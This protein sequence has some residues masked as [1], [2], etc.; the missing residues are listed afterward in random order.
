[1][2]TVPPHVRAEWQRSRRSHRRGDMV[3]AVRCEH[4]AC[5]GR[6]DRDL[7]DVDVVLWVRT[8]T[9][10]H[11]AA[12][13]VAAARWLASWSLLDRLTVVGDGCTSPDVL[14]ALVRLVHAHDQVPPAVELR[15]RDGEVAPG[16]GIEV[17]R[18]GLPLL[19]LHATGD[20][21]GE[22]ARLD[23]FLAACGYH[24]R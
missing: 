5:A 1:M 8:G 17:R 13:V 19:V 4:H 2:F 6:A 23:E 15:H 9:S 14:R 18:P 24:P 7:G 22:E 11:V 21:A 10:A 3:A 16:R 12:Q 20:P